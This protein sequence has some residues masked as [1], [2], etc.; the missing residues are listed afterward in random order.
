MFRN[1]RA[2]MLL[3]GFVGLFCSPLISVDFPTATYTPKL[4]SVG[5]HGHDPT[6][7]IAMVGRLL[8]WNFEDPLSG[9][10][11]FVIS[12]FDGRE[13]DDHGS[14]GDVLSEIILRI[15]LSL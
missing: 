6:R 7:S 12:S 9:V 3:L 11:C 4:S 14:G 13:K 8:F 15:T 1:A 2:L 5:G 10:T